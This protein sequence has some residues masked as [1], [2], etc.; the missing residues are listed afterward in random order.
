MTT[1]GLWRETVTMI[2]MK[3]NFQ[4]IYQN[5]CRH[6]SAVQSSSDHNTTQHNCSKV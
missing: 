3:L 2:M 6:Y 4:E 5:V 1:C